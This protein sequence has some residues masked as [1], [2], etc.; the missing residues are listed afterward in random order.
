MLKTTFLK[1]FSVFIFGDYMNFKISNSVNFLNR[2]WC[3]LKNL[4]LLLLPLLLFVFGGV[5]V[6]GYPWIADLGIQKGPCSCFLN[7]VSGFSV[8]F[9]FHSPSKL[10]VSQVLSVGVR[11]L[12]VG[13]IGFITSQVDLGFGC[14]FSSKYLFSGLLAMEGKS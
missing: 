6:G 14:R 3:S 1:D 11:E 5:C 4:V 9:H 13:V 8:R 7:H 12:G 2:G 10:Q